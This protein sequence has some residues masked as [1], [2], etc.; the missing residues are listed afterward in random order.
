MWMRNE[1]FAGLSLRKGH[2]DKGDRLSQR[3]YAG[4]ALTCPT[5]FCRGHA[6]GA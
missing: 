3:G 2:A 5:V 6:A 4:C 1:K